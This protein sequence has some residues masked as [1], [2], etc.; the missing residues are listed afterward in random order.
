MK[1][2]SSPEH[3]ARHFV[4]L[5]AFGSQ[6]LHRCLLRASA[7]SSMHLLS[8]LGLPTNAISVYASTIGRQTQADRLRLPSV[9]PV[10]VTN[11]ATVPA[12]PSSAYNGVH[13]VQR[14]VEKSREDEETP[15]GSKGHSNASVR[16]EM[17][18]SGF[19][20][21]GIKWFVSSQDE[22]PT[23]QPLA[24]LNLLFW[25]NTKHLQTDSQRLSL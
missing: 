9:A 7:G 5:A 17:F 10:H 21:I 12:T 3:G 22:T 23:L 11:Q 8:S 13:D 18:F 25:Q 6:A 1:S 24:R 15:I 19:Q 20:W 2:I 16:K 4:P 14:E